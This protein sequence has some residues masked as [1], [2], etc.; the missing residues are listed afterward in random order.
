MCAW[1]IWLSGW[2]RSL[3]LQNSSQITGSRMEKSI[4]GFSPMPT[5]PLTPSGSGNTCIQSRHFLLSSH[6]TPVW[7][8]IQSFSTSLLHAALSHF[9]SYSFFPI[10]GWKNKKPTQCD[11]AMSKEANK[12]QQDDTTAKGACH[13]ALLLLSSICKTHVRK[14][15]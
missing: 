15:E 8:S 7:M 4:L 5:S 11:L 3:F 12:G 6:T 2:P 9:L 13:Q 14:R 10:C 1:N